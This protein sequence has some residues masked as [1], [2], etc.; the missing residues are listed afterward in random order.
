MEKS[1]LRILPT[2]SRRVPNPPEEAPG[3]TVLIDANDDIVAT[4]GEFTPTLL[5]NAGIESLP[6]DATGK[7]LWGFI[8]TRDVRYLYM[9]ILNK[10]RSWQLPF[11]VSYRHDLPHAHR[12]MTMEF[13]AAPKH[14]VK[15]LSYVRK[16]HPHAFLPL[17][18]PN[19]TR[20]SQRVETCAFCRN[21]HLDDAWTDLDSSAA[22][23]LGNP[24]PPPHLVE[25]VCPT[26]HDFI[27]V[28]LKLNAS[29]KRF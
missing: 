14:G 9:L 1:N 10:V 20:S 22:Y 23:A 11:F 4:T 26:C 12:Q 25:C 3:A 8:R 28:T 18:D 27:N 13:A 2:V 7:S 29:L 21:I 15:L 16:T 19:A 17:L 5:S 6:Q 24:G